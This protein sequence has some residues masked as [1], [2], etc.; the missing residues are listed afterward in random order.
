MSFQHTGYPAMEITDLSGPTALLLRRIR[1][2]VWIAV[3]TPVEG[4]FGSYGRSVFSHLG[5]VCSVFFSVKRRPVLH[6]CRPEPNPGPTELPDQ[7][8]PGP[9]PRAERLSPH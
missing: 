7:P 2:S 6:R 1:L 8:A 4:V 9:H 3:A 5:H